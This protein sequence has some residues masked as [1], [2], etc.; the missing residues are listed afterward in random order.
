[1]GETEPSWA[2]GAREGDAEGGTPGRCFLP[3]HAAQAASLNAPG[4]SRVPPTLH[5]PRGWPQRPPLARRRGR[6]CC[7]RRGLGGRALIAGSPR[8]SLGSLAPGTRA[9]PP[10]EDSVGNGAET[11]RVRTRTLTGWSPCSL[12]REKVPGGRHPEIE[13][14]IMGGEQAAGREERRQRGQESWGS[15]LGPGVPPH[16]AAQPSPTASASRTGRGSGHRRLLITASGS[17][18]GA[19]QRRAG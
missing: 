2:L 8:S 11:A 9:Q 13:E 19:P 1:M 10:A 15:A 7:A 6:M 16:S 17:F 18:P 4:A 5:S 14:G 3:A 12:G